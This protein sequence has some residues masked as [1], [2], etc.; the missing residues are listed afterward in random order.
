MSAY[1][2]ALVITKL[3]REKLLI[4]RYSHVYDDADFDL[5]TESACLYILDI[6]VYIIAQWEYMFGLV[7]FYGISNIVGY[8]IPNPLYTYIY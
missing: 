1:F 7:G 3:F 4:I 5:S 8:L 2:F 6:E